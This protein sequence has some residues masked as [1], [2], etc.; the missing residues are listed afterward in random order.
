MTETKEHILKIAF[1]LFLLKNFKEVTMQDIVKETGLSKGAF[2]HYFASKEQVFQEVVGKYYLG[3]GLY[4]I[5]T[6]SQTSLKAFYLDCLGHI[7]HYIQF[8]LASAGI[9]GNVPSVVNY[10]NLVF[11]A[12]GRLPD[13]REKSQQSQ[14]AELNLWQ[15][16]IEQAVESGEIQ[17]VG[18]SLAI[19][20]LFAFSVDSTF[21]HAVMEGNFT[22]GIDDIQLMWDNLYQ[23][24][25][26]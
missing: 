21:I 14:L 19:A 7:Q 4:D 11:D 9:D 8:V 13:F 12:L 24:L 5:Q 26:A 6:L 1:R 3:E 23:I 10:F 15:K 17:P 2:Y 16:M 22:R 18:S 25:K 20:K